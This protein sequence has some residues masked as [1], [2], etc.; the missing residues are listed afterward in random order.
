MRTFLAGTPRAPSLPSLLL[1]VLGLGP[2]ACAPSQITPAKSAHGAEA[3]PIENVDVNDDGFA[4]ASL[5]VLQT[6]AATPRRFG[7]LVGVV[8]RQLER[9]TRYFEAG[10]DEMALAALRGALYLL[11]ASELRSEMLAGRSAALSHGAAALAKLGNEGQAEA[12]YSLLVDRLPAGAERKD[13]EE[14]LAALRRW[15]QDTRPPGSMQAR[16]SAQQAALQQALLDPST[17]A[18]ERAH[19]ETVRWAEQAMT[20][21]AEQMA[22]QSL[23]EQDES[24]EAFRAIRTGPLTLVALYLRQG[25][26]AGALQALDDENISRITAPSLRERVE[27][28]ATDNDPDAWAELFRLFESADGSDENGISLDPDL[29]RAASWGAAIELYRAEPRSFRAAMPIC[30]LMLAHGMAEVAPLILEQALEHSDQTREASWALRYVL[31]AIRQDEAL[32]DLPAARR[33][34]AHSQALIKLSEREVYGGRVTPSSGR[35]H[36]FMGAIEAGAGDLE[37]A[38]PE[39]VRAVQLEPTADALRLL[40]SIERQRKDLKGALAALD[41]V[42]EISKGT[43]DAASQAETQLLR[44]EVQRELAAGNPA[45]L[46][47]AEES[48]ES[49]LMLGLSAR[50]AAQTGQDLAVA[51]RVLGR[52]LE[53]YDERDAA[54]RAAKRAYEA[55][56]NDVR[57]M[58]ETVLDSSRRALTLGDLR[59]ARDSVRRAVSADLA[60]EDTVYAALWLKLLEQRLRVTSDGTAEEA[61]QKIDSSTGWVAKLAAWG[62]GR[63]SSKELL[64]QASTPVERV[65]ATFYAAM[66]VPNDQQSLEGLQKVASSEAIQLVEVTIARDLLASRA[67]LPKPKLPPNISLP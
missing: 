62:R 66:S 25:D 52:V 40:A 63:L 19:Q 13:A 34:F 2:L 9:S 58:T 24:L 47:K 14:H 57:Q 27:S 44:F 12:L 56:R 18:L 5:A 32:G 6:Q 55:S 61:L 21:G 3:T 39:V 48:L 1:L 45:A 23:F 35:L 51:E 67:K 16:A 22:P 30:S 46:A 15:Q 37:R 38:Q 29:A 4:A 65:E 60:D 7:L 26:A 43:G 59:A 54:S 53:L 42:I 8:Q 36:F 28:A 10:H 49:A 64:E 11:R 41:R 31:E 20:F 50:T 33:T 17:Q